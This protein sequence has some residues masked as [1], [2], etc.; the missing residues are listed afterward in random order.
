MEF[1]TKSGNRVCIRS[2]PFHVLWAGPNE[3][4]E[5]L[6]GVDKRID[7]PPVLPECK[8]DIIWSTESLSGDDSSDS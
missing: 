6:Q 3:S 8:F 2:R 1:P 7:E 5:K 4:L